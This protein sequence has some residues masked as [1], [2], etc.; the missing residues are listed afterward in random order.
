M[1]FRQC[2]YVSRVERVGETRQNVESRHAPAGTRGGAVS[3]SGV[4]F[5]RLYF[6]LN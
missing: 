4:R 5:A 3:S 6:N 2:A 1:G